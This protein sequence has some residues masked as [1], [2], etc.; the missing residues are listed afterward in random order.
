MAL[1]VTNLGRNADRLGNKRIS[2]MNAAAREGSSD[3]R[4]GAFG[5]EDAING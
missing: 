2:D 3:H 4:A 1:N 5:G